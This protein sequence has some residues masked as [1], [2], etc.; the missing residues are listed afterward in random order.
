MEEQKAISCYYIEAA[1][2]EPVM[3]YS[4]PDKC[5]DRS[6]LYNALN[7]KKIDASDYRN[8]TSKE[9]ITPFLVELK[10]DEYVLDESRLLGY[11]YL[12]KFLVGSCNNDGYDNNNDEPQILFQTSE[13]FANSSGQI[14]SGKA[15]MVEEMLFPKVFS[16]QGED[17]LSAF[18]ITRVPQLSQRSLEDVMRNLVGKLY[19]I[20]G[21][22]MPASIN[23]KGFNV[24]VA[25]FET[26][27]KDNIAKIEYDPILQPLAC[28]HRNE[29]K[30]RFIIVI[31]KDGKRYACKAQTLDEGK[32]YQV[33]KSLA[34]TSSSA[35][36]A[37]SASSRRPS[38]VSASSTNAGSRRPSDTNLSTKDK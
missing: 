2:K 37:T 19:N 8:V 14:V 11:V 31:C 12:V 15:V 32:T 27:S 13:G 16:C 1:D 30:L 29:D 28:S 25:Q 6:H 36:S 22:Y 35:T 3:I 18:K 33:P 20:S 9:I 34:K 21:N 5:K 4:V 17:T 26:I 7:L 23:Y 38:E 24:P 10:N